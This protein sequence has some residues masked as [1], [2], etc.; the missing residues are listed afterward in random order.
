M[1]VLSKIRRYLNNN[2]MLSIYRAMVIPSFDY[3]D[4]FIVG[5]GS[6]LLGKLQK[7]QEKC[8][9][10]C[11]NVRNKCDT[12]TLHNRAKVAKLSDRRTVH[13]NNFLFR[14]KEK[15]IG[16]VVTQSQGT[17]TRARAAPSFE[18]ERPNN[19]TFKRSISYFGVMQW[20]SLP[21]KSRNEKCFFSFKALQKYNLKRKVY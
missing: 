13:V 19:E 20:N 14:R 16:L 4:V 1:F 17:Q 2:A 7:L 5:A 21:E 15:G 9:K 12:D 3:V 10:I 8:L 11:L 6:S 18:V